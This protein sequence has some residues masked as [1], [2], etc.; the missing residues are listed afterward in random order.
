MHVLWQW[1]VATGHPDVNVHLSL[2]VFLRIRWHVGRAPIAVGRRVATFTV[3]ATSS[4]VHGPVRMH[5]FWMKLRLPDS[6]GSTA[7]L[8][9]KSCACGG[10]VVVEHV[11]VQLCVV[12]AFGRCGSF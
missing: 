3:V 4:A 9:N 7:R 1:S 6:R 2:R 5:S 12:F 8:D 10:V 11:R